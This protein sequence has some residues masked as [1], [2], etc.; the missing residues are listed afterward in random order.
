VI[1]S[2]QPGASKFV[3]FKMNVDANVLAAGLS[4]T[5]FMGFVGGLIPAYTA[6]RL[7]P[8]EALR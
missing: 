1:G 7:K 8:L 3:V 6:V 4:L 5:L 2:G